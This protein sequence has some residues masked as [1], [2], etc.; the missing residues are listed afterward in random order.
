MIGK[1]R[2]KSHDRKGQGKSHDRKGQGKSHRGRKGQGEIT[3]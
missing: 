3:R 2:G 1:V